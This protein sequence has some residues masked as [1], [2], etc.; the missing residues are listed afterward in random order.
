MARN[1]LTIDKQLHNLIRLKKPKTS[2][3]FHCRNIRIKSSV[4]IYFWMNILCG[5][6][7]RASGCFFS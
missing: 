4:F 1:D 3:G 5:D 6:K 7:S 2:V